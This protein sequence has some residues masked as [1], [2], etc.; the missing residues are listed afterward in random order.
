MHAVHQVVI[1]VT[2]NWAGRG[3]FVQGL[4]RGRGSITTKDAWP[5]GWMILK[6]EKKAMSAELPRRTRAV[7]RYSMNRGKLRFAN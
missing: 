7:M 4:D 6:I 2:D 1:K 3:S 5:A